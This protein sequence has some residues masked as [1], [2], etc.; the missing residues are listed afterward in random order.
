M[1]GGWFHDNNDTLW[2][3]LA[4][5]NLPDSQLSRESKM[6]PSVAIDIIGG[7]DIIDGDIHDRPVDLPACRPASRPAD[8]DRKQ[9]GTCQILSLA[10]NPRSSRVKCHQDI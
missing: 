9:A 4:S 8:L 10:K 1:A 2:P 7:T 6:K 5:W 3:H